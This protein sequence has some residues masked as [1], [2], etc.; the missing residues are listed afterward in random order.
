MRALFF[1]LIMLIAAGVH[2]A[3]SSNI[4]VTKGYVRGLPPG[5]TNTAAFMTIENPGSEDKVLT[6]ATTPIAESVSI[7]ATMSNNGMMSMAHQMSLIVPANGKAVL[8]SGGLHLMLMGLKGPIPQKEVS[9]TLEFQNNP[10]LTILL[11]VVSVLD[12]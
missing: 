7:H 12:E 8:E 1:S 11:P 3:D 10:D 2:A 5:V 4:L 9:L 6:G